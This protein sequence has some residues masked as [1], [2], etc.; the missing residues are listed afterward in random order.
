M[1]KMILIS[2]FGMLFGCSMGN[3]IRYESDVVSRIDDS[4][5][6][7]VKNINRDEN[8][9]VDGVIQDYICRGLSLRGYRC[10]DSISKAGQILN[11]SYSVGD[12]FQM[13]HQ[14]T[15]N[16]YGTVGYTADNS[17]S[18]SVY[19][20][21]V[22]WNQQTNITPIRGVVG[23]QVNEY[24]TYHYP[25]KISIVGVGIDSS[26]L[27]RFSVYNYSGRSDI[28]IDAPYMLV[29]MKY[30]GE[31]RNGEMYVMD[32]DSRLSYIRG[33]IKREKVA[34]KNNECNER[35]KQMNRCK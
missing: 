9:F 20:N 2:L 7:F 27:W 14:Y 23:K 34:K 8:R 22:Y 18:A 1:K 26:L 19:G 29:A 3:Y 10:V 5:D 21:R 16:V 11:F 6:V 24:Q 30:I 12:E 28:R 13:T 15:T 31:R 4:V 32:D 35:M 25:K 17:G 33:I